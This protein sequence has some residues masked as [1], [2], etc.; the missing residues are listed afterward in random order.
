M[1]M[2][3]E[4]M[5]A[6]RLKALPPYLF[7]DI[8]RKRNEAL[9]AGRDV[10]NLGVGDPDLPT[11]AFIVERM[12][13][14]IRDPANHCY[15]PG[16]GTLELRER[17]VQWFAGRFAVT[18]DPEKEVLILIGSKE[19]IGHFPL[20]TVNPGET[21][22][23]P[24]PGYPV[25]RSAA[26]FAGAQPAEMVLRAQNG[27]LPD[28]DAIP[29]QVRRSASLMFLNYPNNPTAATAEL[30]D[31]ERMVS[32]ARE[33]NIRIAQDAAYSELSFEARPPSILQVQGAKDMAVEFH[34]F[35]KTFAMTGWRLGFAVGNADMLGALAKVKNNVDSGAFGAVQQAGT[36]ALKHIDHPEVRAQ[37]AVYRE[38]RDVFCA[39]MRSCGFELETPRAT[40]YV[41]CKCP[42]G[43]NSMGL[44]NRVLD[45][46]DVVLIPGVGFGRSGEGYLRAAMTLPV[47]R[48]R[49]ATERIRR[50]DLARSERTGNGQ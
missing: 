26:I 50:L 5:Q 12:S 49:E 1:N 10:I 6:D 22:L 13:Q 46:A 24:D 36:E 20:A 18:L 37:L 38:R 29:R 34:S 40:F 14:T 27:W 19:G 30:A 32:F 17:I 47:E 39:G 8:D 35:S 43:Y 44:A 33:Y 23:V 48:I 28:L 41:W 21:V 31:F 25:Y 15:P 11:P 3:A 9:A 2:E 45:E 4:R 7:V 42:V 16:V